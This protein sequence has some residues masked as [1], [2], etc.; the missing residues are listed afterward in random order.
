MFLCT[1]ST[2]IGTTDT[3]TTSG[4]IALGTGLVSSGSLENF[5][6]IDVGY[7]AAEVLGTLKA[8][9]GTTNMEVA[10]NGLN[11]PRTGT[12]GDLVKTSAER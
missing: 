2:L 7:T 1:V 11:V 8:G 12:S 6:D 4:H 3:K 10:H 9:I 5:A